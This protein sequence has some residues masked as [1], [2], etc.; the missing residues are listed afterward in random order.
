MSEENVEIVK[1]GVDA[2]NRRDP[3]GMDELATPDCEW[4]TSMGPIEGEIF[5]GREG[6]ETYFARLSDAWEEFRTIAEDLRDLG[7]SVLMLGRI[8]GRGKGSGVPIDT[9]LGQIFDFREGKVCRIRSY[10]DHR[11][12]LKAVG[13]EE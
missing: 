9:P 10:L 8:E 6:G 1:R 12:A 3:D 2:F 4:V 13:L 11:E 5:R 7:D